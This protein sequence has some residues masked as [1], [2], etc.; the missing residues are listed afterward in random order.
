MGYSVKQLLTLELDAR[1]SEEKATELGLVKTM[2]QRFFK[3]LGHACGFAAIPVE[4]AVEPG[5]QKASVEFHVIAKPGL[6][7]CI[8]NQDLAKLNVFVDPVTRG[9][10]DRGLTEPVGMSVDNQEQQRQ[11]PSIVTG[12]DESAMDEELIA[13][14]KAM[15]KS[16]RGKLSE[17]MWEEYWAV[18]EKYKECWLRPRAGKFKGPPAEFKV[19]GRP[20]RS[21]LRPLPPELK[22]ELDKHIDEMLKHN[23]DSS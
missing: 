12:V 23:V 16:K 5:G 15:V 4:M 11:Q 9:L 8:S 1:C 14:A 21:R 13:K 10:V 2:K 22:A 18:F 19:S 3:G 6:S 7:M 17:E 20:V